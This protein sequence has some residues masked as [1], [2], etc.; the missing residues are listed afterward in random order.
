MELHKTTFVVSWIQS[1]VTS[2]LR[3]K[4]RVAGSSYV[5]REANMSWGDSQRAAYQMVYM[6]KYAQRMTESPRHANWRFAGEP[7]GRAEAIACKGHV[8]P[9]PGGLYPSI[10][11]SLQRFTEEARKPGAR[12]STAAIGAIADSAIATM[13]T[14]VLKAAAGGG[15]WLGYSYGTCALVIEGGQDPRE[16]LLTHLK[17]GFDNLRAS[18]A[19]TEELWRQMIEQFNKPKVDYQAVKRLIDVADSKFGG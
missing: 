17:A 13:P 18:G 19:D 10:C 8:G 11:A 3:K 6:L 12:I 14:P 5:I 1:I 15:S 16:Q 7:I 9:G 4:G 2:R